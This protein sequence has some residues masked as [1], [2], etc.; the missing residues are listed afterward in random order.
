MESHLPAGKYVPRRSIPRIS[1]KKRAGHTGALFSEKIDKTLAFSIGA[2]YYIGALEARYAPVAQLDRV[3][4]Y[5]PKG[6]GF[7]SLLAY[8]NRIC[9]LTNAVFSNKVHGMLLIRKACV[10]APKGFPSAK[11]DENP[12]S[13][14]FILNWGDTMEHQGT[15]LLET[16]RLILRRFCPEDA[17]AAYRNWAS[18]DEVTKFLSW[19]THKS[20]A[21]T[22]KII[23]S[24]VSR[25]GDK[26]YYQ[27]AIVPKENGDE[28]VGTISVV[29]LNEDLSVVDIGYCIGSPWWHQG[30]TAE[31]FSVLLPFF[32]EKVRV[33]RIEACHDPNNPNSGRVMT[34]C[35]LRYE[36]TL[37]Q[38]DRNN[39]GIV[40]VSI[41]GLLAEEYF[42]SKQK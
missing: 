30:I 10:L 31:A 25:Y 4:G 1:H 36:G 5:E 42:I 21:T 22:E 18:R 3:F 33:N 19:P 34:K 26:K 8:Q 27:W 28:P 40:D 38:R 37:R 32:F 2:C 39:Q 9:L 14:I 7:E 15:V 6:R 29:G 41:Y 24:W 11:A 35:G 13:V 17:P 16:P 20:Q 23:R 12:L